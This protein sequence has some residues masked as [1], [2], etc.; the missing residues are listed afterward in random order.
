MTYTHRKNFRLLSCNLQLVVV[1]FG[2]HRSLSTRFFGRF[3]EASH[4]WYTAD[5][6][7]KFS[8][9]KAQPWV[10][11]RD[12]DRGV[13][14]LSLL[15]HTSKQRKIV[16]VNSDR[17]RKSHGG[18]RLFVL[19][20]R[21]TSSTIL[22]YYFGKLI[23]SIPIFLAS[24]QPILSTREQ[25]ISSVEMQVSRSK[26]KIVISKK[27]VQ[28]YKIIDIR[29]T[30]HINDM[31]DEEIA[32][33]WYIHGE[34]KSIKRTM[35]SEVNFITLGEPIMGTDHTTRGLEFRTRE[36][37][38]RIRPTG[39]SPSMLCLTSKTFNSCVVTTT[40]TASAKST[41]DTA[42]DVS[43]NLKPLARP[44][45]LK[46]ASFDK[47]L[48]HCMNHFGPWAEWHPTFQFRRRFASFVSPCRTELARN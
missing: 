24:R 35:T 15:H 44:T 12:R 1:F 29:S 31:T 33:A 38:E 5:D 39:S 7:S 41:Q 28:F 4:S 22:D 30:T 45:K 16:I 46:S 18:S 40:L 37:R 34:M 9:T 43:L 13:H 25:R 36:G 8:G 23:S 27:S 26:P 17:R 6:N 2:S 10:E 14:G 48:D 21:T 19:R 42:E 47:T 20:S 32:R 11:K 3:T